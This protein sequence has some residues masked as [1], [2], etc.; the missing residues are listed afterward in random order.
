MVVKDESAPTSDH[1][2]AKQKKRWKGVFKYYFIINGFSSTIRK[3]AWTENRTLF[4]RPL[5]QKSAK[6]MVPNVFSLYL[7]I[8]EWPVILMPGFAA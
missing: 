3:R 4:V 8:R 6:P 5:E 7:Q 2:D 1:A